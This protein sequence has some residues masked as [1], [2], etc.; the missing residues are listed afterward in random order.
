MVLIILLVIGYLFFLVIY[1]LIYYIFD[2]G[3]KIKRE[4]LKRG[5]NIEYIKFERVT[6]FRRVYKSSVPILYDEN[7]EVQYF[8]FF[9][10]SL[11][12][13]SDTY[14]IFVLYPKEKN[15]PKNKWDIK[16]L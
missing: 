15:F 16:I 14:F 1:N 7:K 10:A 3:S 2:N 6:V 12:L 5:K 11:I 8:E 13:K 4:L 9:N